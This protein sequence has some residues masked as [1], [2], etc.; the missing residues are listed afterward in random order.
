MEQV[1]E[2]VVKPISEKIGQM[3]QKQGSQDAL[4]EKLQQIYKIAAETQDK[5]ALAAQKTQADIQRKDAE[6]AA[7][8][9]RDDAKTSAEIHQSEMRAQA[10]VAIKGAQAAHG[11]AVAAKVNPTK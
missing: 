3:D 11:A 6:A 4:L 5:N 2:Q 7:R 9:K 8:I 1:G 10:D